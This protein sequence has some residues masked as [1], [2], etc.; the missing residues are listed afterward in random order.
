MSGVRRARPS[1]LRVDFSRLEY[2]KRVVP[3]RRSTVLRG[4]PRRSLRRRR[5]LPLR[6]VSPRA[7]A[8]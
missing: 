8:V 3:A 2:E 7:P 5:P 1:R 4:V 6:A